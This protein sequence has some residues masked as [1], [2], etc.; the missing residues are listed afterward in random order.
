MSEAGEGL[1]VPQPPVAK[2]NNTERKESEG[3]RM[4]FRIDNRHLIKHTIACMDDNRFSSQEHREDLVVFQDSA[5]A[6]SKRCYDF[7]AGRASLKQFTASGGTLEEVTGFLTNIEQG[8]EFG[9]IRQQTEIYIASLK[10]EWERNYPQ[11]SQVVQEMAGVDLNKQVT[12]WVTHPSLKNGQYLGNNDIA[13]GHSPEWDNYA[14][15]YLWHEVLH[16]YLDYTDLSHA[17]IQLIADNELRVRLNEGE[18]Y[19]PFVGHKNLF[20]LMDKLLP[21]WH[22]YLA[23]VPVEGKKDLLGFEKVLRTI[24]EFQNESQGQTPATPVIE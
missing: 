5:R 14:T 24:P 1:G 8:S 6:L 2:L 21:Y 20:P 22:S 15:V 11:T 7:I 9:K 3:L 17:L 16:S 19:P 4:D 13:W 18:T 23:E 10:A 12:I